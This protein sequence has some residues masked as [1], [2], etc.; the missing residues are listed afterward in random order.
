MELTTSRDLYAHLSFVCVPLS[1][2]IE[3]CRKCCGG[4]G[5]SRFCGISDIWVDYVPAQTYEG[6]NI[7]MFLQTA[8][9]LVKTFGG[10]RKGKVKFDG[11]SPNYYM[12]QAAQLGLEGVL[13][14]RARITPEQI[15]GQGSPEE[16]A[17]AHQAAYTHRA[18]RLLLQSVADL[19]A[20]AKS[21][22][23]WSFEQ[24]WEGCKVVLV[25]MARA[26][27]YHVLVRNFHASLAGMTMKARTAGAA[28]E[29]KGISPPLV[30]V[31]RRLCD[32]FCWSS[33]YDHYLGEFTADGY[34]SFPQTEA[35]RLRQLELLGSIRRDAVPLVDSFDFTDFYLNSALGRFDGD[36]YSCMMEWAQR[37]P[38]NRTEI[39]TGV[40]EFNIPL[41]AAK[42]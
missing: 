11:T 39:A 19:G 40:E 2:G 10:V 29:S 14:Q 37:N 7:V 32:L 38:I 3:T 25:A 23:D 31:L 41:L 30:A 35:I 28:K 13:A 26:H 22:P 34:F 16:I 21:H 27:C 20:S 36:V 15:G 6:D 12:H 18:S 42:L 1:V 24:H 5:Y 9:A 4:H 33:I 8:R 17:E